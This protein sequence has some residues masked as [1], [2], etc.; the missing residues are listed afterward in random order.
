MADQT[1]IAYRQGTK[2][3]FIAGRSFAIGKDGMTVPKGSDIFFDG[4]TV[5]Y[6]GMSFSHP[7]FRGAVKAGWATLAEDYDPNDREAERPVAANIQVRHPTLGGNPMQGGT[8]PLL[9][10]AATTVTQTDEREVGSVSRH[11]QATKSH[12]NGHHHGDRVEP[13]VG[14]SV[15]ESQDGVP[16][17]KLRT[18][19]TGEKAK[20]QRT[21]VSAETAGSRIREA[22]SPQPI[23]AGQGLTEEEYLSRLQPEQQEEYLTKKAA[24]RGQYVDEP[25][26]TVVAQIRTSKP[27]QTSDGITSTLTTGGGTETWDGAGAGSGAPS[28][29]ST[30]IVDGIKMTN[31]NGPSNRV[32]PSA[33]SAEAHKPPMLKDGSVEVRRMVAKQLCPDFPNLY[34]F[35]QS[36]RKKIARLQA[37]FEDRPD[38]IRAVFAA[39]SDD[40]KSM[41]MQEFPQ[42]FSQ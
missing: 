23:D 33:R 7:Q 29:I 8:R 11:A 9:G 34:D 2:L 25:Q 13:R 39:E 31:T 19:N 22:E 37:D 4:T 38:V 42:A 14:S 20:T 41:L 17:R 15:A 10:S 16:V 24:L 21:I 28:K 30:T 40:F 12:N 36:P 5:E 6:G 26:R 35:A 3:H 1:Q 32:Q 18:S 27:S